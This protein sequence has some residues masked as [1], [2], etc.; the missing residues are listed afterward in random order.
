LQA[1]DE[2]IIDL[3]EGGWIAHRERSLIST[4]GLPY[5]YLFIFIVF[6]ENAGVV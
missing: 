5:S 6:Y 1:L 4:I 2:S 3:E